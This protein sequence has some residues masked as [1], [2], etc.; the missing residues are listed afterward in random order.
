[1]EPNTTDEQARLEPDD[2][3]LSAR[4]CVATLTPARDRDWRVR[5]GDLDWD[6]DATLNHV[7]YCLGYYAV[8]V[9]ARATGPLPFEIGSLVSGHAPVASRL[10]GL[11][12]VAAVL[13]D[14]IRSAPS[15]VQ[16]Y[17]PWGQAN[18]EGFIAMGCDEIL[19]HTD[20]IARGLGLAWQPPEALCRR[21]VARLFPWA[22]AAE[23]PWSALRWANG[24]MAL[25]GHAR[26]GPD[27]AWQGGPLAEWDGT[28]K[29]VP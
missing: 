13:A 18:L 6:A 14:V 8:H 9:A 28:T 27:W 16:A 25:V 10:A 5:A 22:P 17:H 12:A 2:L 29:K 26:L 23:D 15:A 4:V 21:I 1:M 7:I 3:R 20:D 11:D 19:I 24:R